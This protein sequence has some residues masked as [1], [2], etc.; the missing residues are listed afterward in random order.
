MPNVGVPELILIIAIVLILFGAGKLPETMRSIGKGVR[1][2]RDAA[3]G[4][5][6]DKTAKPS[7]TTEPKS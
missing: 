4:E 5:E 7:T 6:K 3:S 1:E 2:F